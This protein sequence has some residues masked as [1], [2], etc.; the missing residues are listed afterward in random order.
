MNAPRLA[1]TLGILLLALP[2]SG[3]ADTRGSSTTEAR[4]Q[5]ADKDLSWKAASTKG[6][7][8]QDY[9]LEKKRVDRLIDA[10]ERGEP[11][12]PAEVERAL[13]GARTAP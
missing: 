2:G 11:V 8:Q 5:A 3:L 9:L 13:K 10:L 4:L 12:D 6:A 1:S 7:P